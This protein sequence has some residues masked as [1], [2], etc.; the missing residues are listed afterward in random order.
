MDKIDGHDVYVVIGGR[1]MDRDGSLVFRCADWL[2]RPRCDEH[3]Q[4]ARLV[5]ETTDFDDYRDVSG[6]KVAATVHLLSPEGDKTYKF[7]QIEANTAVEDA[8]FQ[9]PPRPAAQTPVLLLPLA[10]RPLNSR[11]AP[12]A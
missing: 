9:E 1:I 5:P 11:R 6:L 4:R 12:S 2:A 8:R 10:R 7:D 3:E